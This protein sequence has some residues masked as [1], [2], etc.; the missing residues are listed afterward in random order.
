MSKS[1]TDDIHVFIVHYKKLK[2]RKEYLDKALKDAGIPESHI[3]WFEDIDRDTMTPEQ[4]AMYE[5]NYDRWYELAAVWKHYNS[6]PRKLSLPEIACTV[7]HI[8]IYKY[9]VDNGIENSIVFED[10]CILKENFAE[11]LPIILEYLTDK[12]NGYDVCYLSDAFGWT[13]DNFN[14]HNIRDNK[15]G[16]AYLTSLNKNVTSPNIPAYKMYSSKGGDSFLLS[17]NGAKMFYDTCKPFPF[18]IDWMHTPSIIRNNLKAFWA[19]PPITSQGSLGQN[20]INNEYSSSLQRPNDIGGPKEITKDDSLCPEVRLTDMDLLRIYTYRKIK[21]ESES[22]KFWALESESK[23]RLDEFT[24]RLET[25]DNFIIV[26]FGDGEMRNMISDN[27]MEH[28]CDGCHYFKGLG[29]DLIQSYIYFLK[30]QNA[31]I[32]KWHSHVYNIQDSIENDYSEEFNHK[33]KFVFYDLLVHKVPFKEEQVRFFKTIQTIK[34][35]KVYISNANMIQSVG[36]LLGVNIGFAIP[37]V[38]SYLQKDNI[39]QSITTSLDNIAKQN[40]I[41]IEHFI[42]IFS[43]GMFAKVLIMILSQRFPNN[44]FIDIGS[45]FDGLIKW[46]RDYNANENYQKELLKVYANN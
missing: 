11:R 6:I 4:L 38:D 22:K 13:V 43:G 31:Y 14:T 10:D 36:K 8:L 1:I 41:T 32:N 5:Y 33:R 26:K 2:K 42:F 29:Q 44:T 39:V 20:D 7:T 40:N 15:A 24:A 12:Q 18:A 23:D 17:N 46:S 16:L 19:H 3:H 9:I 28:N 34:R 21:G 27:E 37:E 30:K 45:T 25:G 35:N